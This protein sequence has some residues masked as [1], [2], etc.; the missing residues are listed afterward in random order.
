MKNLYIICLLSIIFDVN[1]YSTITLRNVKITG[2]DVFNYV[3][4]LHPYQLND[5]F[6]RVLH[7][8]N[9]IKLKNII[10]EGNI[11]IDIGAHTGDTAVGYSL[12]VGKKG[13]VYAFEPNPDAF[14]V[15]LENSIHNQNIKPINSAIM[16][17]DGEYEFNYTDSNLCNGGF[18][19]MLS[20]GKEKMGNTTIKVKGI[21]FEKWINS[22]ISTE[23][24][25][26]IT[27]IKIDT[28]GYDRFILKSIKNW[29][30]IHKP[31]LECEVYPLL[32]AKERADYYETIIDCGYLPVNDF[33]GEIIAREDFVNL[34]RLCDI[35]CIPAQK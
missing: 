29:L 6:G 25:K 23:D 11:A 17:E 20:V 16:M 18:G 13:L 35:F 21:N 1:S 4:W 7:Y 26:R 30:K 8:E 22:E 10:G 5:D 3:V 19:G 9:L 32:T 15:L 28:E 31:I 12:A 24:Q 27:Y 14:N 33:G 34:N 2:F